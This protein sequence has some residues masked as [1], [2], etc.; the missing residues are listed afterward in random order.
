MPY[1]FSIKGKKAEYKRRAG[2]G[3]AKVRRQAAPCPDEVRHKTTDI[4]KKRKNC[5][6]RRRTKGA[7]PFPS[8]F[9]ERENR[10]IMAEPGRE[11]RRADKTKK[12]LHTGR[13]EGFF[14]FP[15]QKRRAY[16]ADCMAWRKPP[17]SISTSSSISQAALPGRALVPMALR[18]GTPFCSPNNSR[19]RLEA[20]L[21]TAGWKAN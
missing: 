20:P 1:A 4:D 3:G 10:K 8:G 21:M 13:C 12:S 2:K 14:L 18:A 7:R 15:R 5:R 19:N 6:C 16:P 9:D 17:Y 11:M